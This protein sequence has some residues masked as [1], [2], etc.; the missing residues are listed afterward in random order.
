MKMDK[1]ANQVENQL[2]QMARKRRPVAPKF[3]VFFVIITIITTLLLS[4]C[5]GKK[6]DIAKANPEQAVKQ[7]QTAKQEKPVQKDPSS[8]PASATSGKSSLVSKGVPKS[9]LG[10]I[11]NGQ[12]YFATDEYIFY[13][14][15]DQNDTAHIYSVK[16]D[17]TDHK[18]IFD[19][20]AWSLTVLD[21]WLYF[22]GNQGAINSGENYLFRISLDGTKIEKL[23][24]EYTEGLCIYDKYLFY[25]KQNVDYQHSRSLC[26]ANLDGS[27][28]QILFP[29]A[30]S[31]TVY[32]DKL[33]HFD[34]QGNMFRYDPDGTNPEV[35]LPAEVD[36]F[37]LSNEKI[38]Y[39]DNYNNICTCDLDGGNYKMIRKEEGLPINAIN[40]SNGKIFFSEYDPKYDYSLYGYKYTVKSCNMDG[41]DVKTVYSGVSVGAYINIVDNKLML[42]EFFASESKKHWCSLIKTMNFDGSEIEILKR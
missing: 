41:S 14:C 10:N 13:S 22:L 36:A 40:A 26:K 21:N 24:D 11:P 15:F 2:T 12:Y 25:M 38:V 4:S 16:H 30:Y 18:K 7:E 37:V 23:N 19:G 5:D 29:F 35:L 17:G 28:E 42:L 9:D 3:I 34:N 6:D 8:A 31:P 27:N 33:F 32:D 39:R 1:S 20:F